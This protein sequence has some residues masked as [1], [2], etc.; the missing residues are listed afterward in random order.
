[1]VCCSSILLIL[2][3]L[4]LASPRDSI[5]R[6]KLFNQISPESVGNFIE[7]LAAEPHLAGSYRDEVVLADF[8]EE[9]FKKYLDEVERFPMKLKLSYT[10]EGPND[11]QHERNKV[12]VLESSDDS[13]E[14][15][16]NGNLVSQRVIY[17]ASLVEAGS[18]EEAHHLVSDLWLAFS[19]NGTAIGQPI[20][21]NYGRK[22]DFEKLCYLASSNFPEL[23]LCE[24]NSNRKFNTTQHPSLICIMKFGKIFRGNKVYR[25]EE[26]GCQGALLFTDPEDYAPEGENINVYPRGSNLPADGGERGAIMIASG[27]V[28]TYGYYSDVN[29]NYYRDQDAAKRQKTKIVAQQIGYGAARVILEMMNGSLDIWKSNENLESPNHKGA[30]AG[31]EYASGPGFNQNYQLRIESN[32]YEEYKTVNTVCG[33]L[34]G[35]TEPDRYVILGNHRD[36]WAFGAIDPSSG[37]AILLEAVKAFGTMTKSKKISW[38][39]KRSLMFCSFAAEEH[40][41][42]GS[43][44]YVEQLRRENF[45]MV[46]F[47]PNL[48]WSN[49]KH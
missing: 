47:R 31:I 3:P 29:M 6:N 43:T 30:M 27:D 5:I 21:V 28:E 2:S 42:I 25:A 40:G 39:P 1:M 23:N 14:S 37:T 48:F 9:H 34:Y 19:P 15:N 16:E 44:E 17:D 26:Y 20:Y 49:Q 46:L 12:Q 22:E 32:N 7:F 4:V 8:I 33:F 24:Q 18:T 41:L 38:R 35:K 45:S 13:L 36:A 10:R 11:T